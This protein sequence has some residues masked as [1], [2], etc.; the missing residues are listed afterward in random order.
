MFLCVVLL[1]AGFALLTLFQADRSIKFIVTIILFLILV[2]FAG[3]RTSIVG[4][5]YEEYK[6]LFSLFDGWGSFDTEAF[7][8]YE[9]A[10]IIIPQLSKFIVGYSWYLNFTFLLFAMLAI[11][12]KLIAIR[13]SNIF[14]LSIII[15]CS[16]LYFGQELITIRAGVACGFFL[17]AIDDIVKKNDKL[18]FLKI[19]IA[20]LFH[21]SSFVFIIV[22]IIERLKVSYKLLYFGIV[23][24][25]IIAFLKVNL[26]TL[27]R[28]DIIFPKVKMYLILLELETD[29]PVNVFNFRILFSLL[30]LFLF[31]S[32]ISVF[33]K[34]KMFPILIKTH[35]LS[36]ILFFSLSPTAM[37]FSL[38]I[39]DLLSVVQILLYPYLIYLF[40]Q[41]I[42]GYLF[43]FL[44]CLINYYYI[45]YV[46]EW[47]MDGYKSWLF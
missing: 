36:I 16:Y 21:Y 39:F 19:G 6:R 40:K 33:S 41:R 10:I 2:L 3:T 22:W 4:R 23:F 46:S 11:G 34:M 5:D 24:S 35:M 29:I 17:L 1:C 20:Y 13:K 37:V 8:L 30:F 26:L 15:Y 27:L 31:V 32:R 47:F 9:P 18:F 44:F 12:T 42:V 28:L 14:F 25:L 7:V 43:I 38:R 45:F